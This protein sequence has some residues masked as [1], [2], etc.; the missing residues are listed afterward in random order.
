MR[1]STISSSSATLIACAINVMAVAGVALRSF[2]RLTST[3]E[4]LG[5]RFEQHMPG[6]DWGNLLR[7]SQ[8][9]N[10][11]PLQQPALAL[12]HGITAQIVCPTPR[13]SQARTY[14]QG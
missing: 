1:K 3:R 13:L 8:P 12:A 6:S 5:Y 10:K 2:L 4:R 14:W 9:G 7:T 11:R